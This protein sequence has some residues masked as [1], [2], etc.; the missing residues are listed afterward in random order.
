[1]LKSEINSASGDK[2]HCTIR[3]NDFG[4]CMLDT[5]ALKV[6]ENTMQIETVLTNI[7]NNVDSVEIIQSDIQYNQKDTTIAIGAHFTPCW[8]S[9]CLF[10]YD[11]NDRKKSVNDPTVLQRLILNTW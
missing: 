7:S 6:V 3:I 11:L 5:C 4:I 2:S 9:A 8:K 1:M 10:V